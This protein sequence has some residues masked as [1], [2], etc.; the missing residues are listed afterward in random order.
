MVYGLSF[1]SGGHQQSP[2]NGDL[3]CC[4]DI[5]TPG[6]KQTYL[7]SSDSSKHTTGKTQKYDDTAVMSSKSHTKIS[8]EMHMHII[9][10]EDINIYNSTATLHLEL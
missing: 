1:C 6:H 10:I 8:I 3:L 7:L 9:Y 4:Y 5:N 2:D